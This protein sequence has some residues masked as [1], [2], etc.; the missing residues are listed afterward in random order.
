MTAA[1][2]PTDPKYFDS[3]ALHEEIDRVFDLCHGCRLCFNLCPSF[4]TM[5]SFIDANDGNSAALTDA[6]RNQVVD[7]CYQCKLC[8]VKCPYVP[9]HE[10][11]LD[12]PRLMSRVHAVRQKQG[13]G[14]KE[15]LTE[16]FLGRTDALG[17]ISVATAPVVNWSTGTPGSWPRR[18]M[19]KTV[20]IASQPP[21]PTV[22][23][24]ALHQRGSRSA[25]VRPPRRRDAEPSRCSPLASSSTWSPPSGARSWRS[26]STTA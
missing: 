11:Q 8:Y 12:F 22:R 23:P 25:G 17:R 15:R 19:E 7:E 13:V 2:D 21:A 26:T 20:G 3:S 4:P 18:V 10:W 9:P 6:E 1:Y 16:Q 5:F 24:P 14:V